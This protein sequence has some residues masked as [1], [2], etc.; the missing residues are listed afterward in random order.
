MTGLAYLIEIDAYDTVAGALKTLRFGSVG[1]THPTAPGPYLDRLTALPTFRRDIFARNT[2]GGENSIATTD[3]VLANPDGALDNLRDYGLAGQR[4]VVLVGDAD[5][6]Y[7][8]FVSL[9][10]GTVGQAL[11]DLATVT[12]KL[13]DRLQDLAQPI[14]TDTYAGNNSLPAGLEGVDDLAGRP[15]PLIY[16][17]ILNLTVPMVNTSRLEDQANDGAVV[18]VPALY[19]KGIALTKGTDYTSQSDMEASA[20][21]SGGY[22]V[23]KS[24]GYM[25]RGSSAA[26][27]ITADITE[28]ATSADRTAAQIAKRIV[29]RLIDPADVETA[30]VTALDTANS[31]VI[32]I[33]VTDSGATCLSVLDTV[34][35]S[36]G[37]WY[38]FDRLGQFRMQ[39]FEAP[40]TPVATLRRFGLGSD[41]AQGEFDIIACR[42]LPTND[43][44]KGLPTWQVTLTYGKNWTVQSGDAVAGAVSDTRRAWLSA[45]TRS[46]VSSDD[47][48]KTPSPGALSKTI[49]TLLRDQTAAQAEAD[50]ILALFKVRRDFVEIDTPLTPAA[51]AAFELGQTVSVVQNRFGYDAGRPMVITGIEPNSAAN[52]LTLAL[53]G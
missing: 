53:W 32:G 2:T 7:S 1:Y 33:A 10:V 14:Q 22:R 3:L 52:I 24:G 44:D 28:G 42:F 36:I 49:D 13:R 4:Y 25:R 5:A 50:R 31:S 23:W 17:E 35:S 12:I 47:T 15:K 45:A 9:I 51:V 16:G 29:E 27:T 41:A 40:G 21:S 18:D 34:L 6:A 46:V 8:D 38:G 48:V 39:R 30:D 20:P 11:F 37:A 43:P 26:G 19:D